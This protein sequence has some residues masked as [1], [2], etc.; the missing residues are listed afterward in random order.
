[1]ENSKI[2]YYVIDQALRQMKDVNVF[3][4]GGRLF[5]GYSADVAKAYQKSH[6]EGDADFEVWV[7]NN[8]PELKK[9]K[10]HPNATY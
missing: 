6:P 2:K 5:L 10:R 8:Y 1:M 3:E 7:Q 9:A 4:C